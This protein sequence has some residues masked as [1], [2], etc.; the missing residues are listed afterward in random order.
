M[1]FGAAEVGEPSKNRPAIVLSD[2]AMLFSSVYGHIIVV[3][4]SASVTT[5]MPQVGIVLK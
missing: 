5:L 1:R 3:P 4:V 2:A